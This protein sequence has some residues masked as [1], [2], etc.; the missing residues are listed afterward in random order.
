MKKKI[1]LNMEQE[2]ITAIKFFAKNNDKSVS[3]IVSEQIQP[4]TG[5]T[6]IPFSSRA[7]GIIKGNKFNNLDKLR[8]EYLKE[9]Y[10]L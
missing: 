2:L 6:K 4:I 5:K 1:T 10:G 3:Q 9:D 8:E 7:S